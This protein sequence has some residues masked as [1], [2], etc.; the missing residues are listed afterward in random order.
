MRLGKPRFLDNELIT[1][2]TNI[3]RT[4]RN[5]RRGQVTIVFTHEEKEIGELTIKKAAED[6]TS[7]K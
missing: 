1:A 3:G 7:E 6:R 5:K 4:G 2:I